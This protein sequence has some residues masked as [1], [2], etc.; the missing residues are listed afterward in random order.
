MEGLYYKNMKIYMC[1]CYR[2]NHVSFITPY[3]TTG[4]IHSLESWTDVHVNVNKSSFADLHRAFGF[5]CHNGFLYKWTESS[6]NSETNDF[7]KHMYT[8][9]DCEVKTGLRWSKPFL[10]AHRAGQSWCLCLNDTNMP[11]FRAIL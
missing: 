6:S 9:N 1:D 4:H 2:V 11:S 10:Q 3:Q 8:N 7:I 5:I